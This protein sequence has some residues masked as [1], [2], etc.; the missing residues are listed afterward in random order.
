M[1]MKK[2]IDIDQKLYDAYI[3]VNG[4]RVYRVTDN[5]VFVEIYMD[6]P[7]ISPEVFWR[8]Y[9]Y[10]G[11]ADGW[12]PQID[13]DSIQFSVSSGQYNIGSDIRAYGKLSNASETVVK[14]IKDHMKTRRTVKKKVGALNKQIAV[15]QKEVQTLNQ[16]VDQL[17]IGL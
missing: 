13:P 12:F 8:D 17:N 1:P 15:M 6:Q 9:A 3:F 14:K 2:T 16:S 10:S 7:G 5:A 11:E 4:F